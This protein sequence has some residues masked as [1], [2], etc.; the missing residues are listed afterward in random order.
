MVTHWGMSERLGPVAYRNGEHHPFLGKEMAEPRE[1]SEHTAQVIDEEISR[2][3]NEASSQAIQTLT[4]H[5]EKLDTLATAL[6]REEELDESEIE[7]LIGPPAYE[8][9]NQNGDSDTEPT[10]TEPVESATAAQSVTD[11]PADSES[12]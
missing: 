6:D 3:L 10:D 4:E 12:C 7:A 9:K 11:E 5:R 2:I 1:Y 8:R